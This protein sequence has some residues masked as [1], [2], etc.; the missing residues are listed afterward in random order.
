MRKL[1]DKEIAQIIELRRTGHSL[2]EIKKVTKKGAGTVFRYAH[3]VVV[4]PEYREVLRCKQGGSRVRSQMQK[5]KAAQEARSRIGRL[6]S[7]DKLLILVALYWGEGTKS[8]LNIINGDPVLLRTF[9]V[10]LCEIGV[11]VADLKFSLRLYE[12][13]SPMQAKKFWARN[14]GISTNLIRVSEIVVGKK[15]G[16]FTF[17]MCR[18]RV[19]KSGPYFKLIM[20]MIESIGEKTGS[21][22]SMDRTS[23]S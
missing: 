1:S 17:G 23:H 13:I 4:A 19:R 6:S 14:F 10:C 15:K 8:E 12:D 21:R 5:D 20:A 18:I 2:P 22:S 16:R 11:P 3:S 7:R 9:C